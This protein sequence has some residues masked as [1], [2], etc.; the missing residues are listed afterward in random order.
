MSITLNDRNLVYI[1]VETVPYEGY[2]IN[3]V[4]HSEVEAEVYAEELR[5][6]VE[7]A[8]VE[9]IEQEVI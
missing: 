7:F 2:T 4:F 1:V 3:K 8:V 5:K 6:E 9:I